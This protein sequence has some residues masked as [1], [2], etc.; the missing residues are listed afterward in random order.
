MEK[1]VTIVLCGDVMT[2]RGIDQILPHPSNPILYESYV[3]DARHYVELAEQ[4]N[5]PI[6]RPVAYTYLWGKMLQ[7]IR[8]ADAKIINLET[9]VT[10]SDNYFDKGINYRMHPENIPCL[11]VA[12]IDCCV[13]ANNHVMD[14]GQEGL[15]ETLETLNK[16][17]IKHAGAG[18]D[19]SEAIEPGIVPVEGKGR[20]LVFSFGSTSSGISR[21]SKATNNT[22]GV[23]LLDD[24]SIETIKHL[25][26]Q[27]T[28][29]KQPHDRVIA[30]IHW[31]GNWGYE[32]PLVHQEF[33]HNLID[34]AQ[35]DIVHGHSSHHFLGIEVYKQKPIIYGCGDLLNDYEG[36]SGHESYKAHLGLLYFVK[37]DVAHGHLVSMK[38]VPTEVKR[39]QIT[40]PTKKDRHWIEKVLNRECGHFGNRV[41]WADSDALSLIWT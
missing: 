32:I 10:Y 28:N 16:V 33:A 24:F 30:S 6:D 22:P 1:E 23:N 15:Q 5:G 3:K 2:G 20:V 4:M 36:I 40:R 37:V 12:H 17:G 26:R 14:W 34:L 9:S 18:R 25:S 7:P 31:G 39:F 11:T 21:V 41:K 13:L 35:V 29:Y 38:L 8:K 27:I 19:S